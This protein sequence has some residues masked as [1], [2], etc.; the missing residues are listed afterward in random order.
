MKS[1]ATAVF[2]LL[3]ST[4]VRA[5]TSSSSED[6]TSNSNESSSKQIKY[7]YTL[8]I[9]DN[10]KEKYS[11]SLKSAKGIFFYDAMVQAASKDSDWKLSVK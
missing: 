11:L 10:V 7:T 3:V 6:T 4:F 1:Q 5:T 2:V 9:G 8:W